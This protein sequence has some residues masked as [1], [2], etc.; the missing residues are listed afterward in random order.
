MTILFYR[1][2]NIC[3]PDIIRTFQEMNIEVIEECTE[4]TDKSLTA[5]KR[6]EL[7]SRMFETHKPT[8]VF[9]INF[10]PG[11]AEVCHL[12]KILYLCWT[13]DSPVLELFSKSIEYDTNRIF[14][15]DKAQFE[16]FYPYCPEGIYHLPLASAVE[17]FDAV[18]ATITAE[19]IARYSCDISFVGSLYN[20]KNPLRPLLDSDELSEHTQG[21]IRGLTEASLKVMGYNFMEAAISDEVVEDIRRASPNFYIPGTL[22]PS[23]A[24]GTTATGIATQNAVTNASVAMDDFVLASA[25]YTAAHYYLGYHVAEAERIRT[26]NTLAQYFKVDLFTRSDTTP[27]QNVCLHEGVKTLTEMPKVFRLS[28]INL[29]MTIKPI[30]TGLP[31]RIFD[32]LG[33][34][35]FLMTNY[36]TE[37]TD[38][39]EIGVDLEAY[40]SLDELVD[41]CAYYLT[42]EDER[43]QIAQKGYER[44]KRYHTY[45]QR[46]LPM[47][48]AAFGQ[49]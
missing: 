4:I 48:K 6:V 31:L 9:S 49:L 19:D 44:V 23:A 30:Q 12:Y 29:N 38:Y 11:I 25:R 20:E 13:V 42:H 32:I 37:L 47:L 10:F 26:L 2:G 14:L 7:V 15:F 41:K 22:P 40:S 35:G 24:P 33:C 16:C 34:G 27:L 39:F 28:K 18:N 46:I 5:A 8:F 43:L 21:F 17:R 1:Y 36:Q 3:E 45:P